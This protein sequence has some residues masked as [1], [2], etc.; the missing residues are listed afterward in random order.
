MENFDGAT[1][2]S[3]LLLDTRSYILQPAQKNLKCP[4]NNIFFQNHV[5]FMLN[6]RAKWYNGQKNLTLF[7]PLFEKNCQADHGQA[8]LFVLFNCRERDAWNFKRLLAKTDRENLNF[9]NDW[10]K[11]TTRIEYWNSYWNIN[12]AE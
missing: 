9:K 7:I 5:F 11:E 10:Q 12:I 8:N 3:S 4:K 1:P 2:P 6:W